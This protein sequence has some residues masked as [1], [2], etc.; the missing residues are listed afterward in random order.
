MLEMVC[1]NCFFSK[2]KGGV[3]FCGKDS[4]NEE[5]SPNETCEEWKSKSFMNEIVKQKIYGR[6]EL[7][8]SKE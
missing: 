7:N 6:R 4:L 2:S 8:E 5:V 3:W 1:R